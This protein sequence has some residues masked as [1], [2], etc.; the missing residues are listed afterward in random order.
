MDYFL[1]VS[2]VAVFVESR[3]KSGFKYSEL[4]KSV[5]FSLPHIRA[6]Y[7]KTTG[8]SLSRYI[9]SRR[10]ANAAFELA[11]TGNRILDIATKYGF[12][13][14]DTFTR[15]FR[16]VTGVTPK[17]FRKLRQ[18]V[19]SAVLCSGVYAVS[20]K[21][22]NHC[23]N[24]TERVVTMSNNDQKRTTD[25]SVILYG[26]PKVYY[27]AYGGCT[28]LPI[29]IKAVANYMGIELDY[30]E[31]MVNCGAAFRLTWNETCWDGGNVDAIFAFDDPSKVYR[32][33]LESLGCEY[34]L[35]GRSKSTE[36]S[37][38]IRFIKEKIDNGI[39]VIALGI[40]GP[41]EAGIIT[42]YRDDGNTLLGWN[43]FQEYPE[44]AGNISFDE[45]GYYVTDKW[46]ENKDTVAVMSLGEVNKDKKYT[47]RDIIENAVEVMTPRKKGEYAKGI[48]AYDAWKKAILDESQ[49]GK[50]MVSPLLAERLMCQ[51]DATDCVADGRK[52]AHDYFKK[53]AEENPEQPLFGQL[54]EQFGKAA[55]G[56][57]KM[58]QLLGGWE[59]GEK[60]MQ[61][62]A[63]RETRV[64]IGKLID[65]C[66]AADEKAL[67]LLT[68]LSKVL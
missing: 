18:P 54:A 60:Q 42:G 29:C 27:G 53:L 1:M 10:I 68:E 56:A 41:P 13:N 62:L 23:Q 37:E 67:S 4:E 28:P 40:I 2:A 50:D 17:E 20:V 55:Y 33:A 25:G 19:G 45:S 57:H 59:R 8:K 38:F 26:V 31:A 9:L 44:F 47:L 15:A 32:C 35:L 7:A 30:S 39:P 5:G 51:G 43:L 6:V 52:N 22:V 12:S 48:Y 24:D 61:A 11:H 34:N 16:R 36:K 63:Q 49:F 64:E 21:P 66:K 65:K 46:W 58:Y 14:H 3:I